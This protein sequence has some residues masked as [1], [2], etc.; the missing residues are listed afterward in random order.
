MRSI[1]PNHLKISTK[2]VIEGG[3]ENPRNKPLLNQNETDW[4]KNASYRGSDE[5]SLHKWCQNPKNL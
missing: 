2:T 1:W 4:P 3:Y 5:L